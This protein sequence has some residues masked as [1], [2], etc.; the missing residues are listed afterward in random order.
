ML[1]LLF[2][3]GQLRTFFIDLELEWLGIDAEQ[4]I[5]RV[6]R[7]VGLGIHRY[8]NTLDRGYDRYADEEFLRV[9]GVGVVEIHQGQQGAQHDD[10][11][12]NRGRHSPFVHRYLEYLE[13][14]DTQARVDQ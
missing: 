6:E 5:A 9:L 8:N 14:D 1:D 11:A 3:L 2:G 7:L 10:A 13:D 12:Q 4:Y